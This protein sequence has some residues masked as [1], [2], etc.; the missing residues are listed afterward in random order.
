M[1]ARQL[2]AGRSRAVSGGQ[3]R[4]RTTPAVAAALVASVVALSAAAPAAADTQGPIDFE[5]YS[6]GSVDGQD[7]WAKTGPFDVAIADNSTFPDAPASFGDQSLRMSD[8]VTSGSFGNQ[9]FSKPT[10][11]AAG[12]PTADTGGFPTGTLRSRFSTS[13]DFA[14]VTPDAEQPG[15]HTSISPDRGDGAR[16]SYV[17]IEDSPTGWNLFFVDYEDVAPLGSDGDLDDGCG[18]GDSFS[19]TEIASDLS[20]TPHNLEIVM[21]LVN[22]P[23]NDI[24]QVFLDGELVHEGT[25]WEDY[26]RFCSE[27]G[28]GEGGPRADQS[29][30]VRN[31]LFR[32]AGT[33]HP[34]NAGAGFLIDGFLVS[35][36]DPSL[37]LTSIC[38]YSGGP[39]DGQHL[40]RVTSTYL[41]DTDYT[42][43][44]P[45]NAAGVARVATTGKTWFLGVQDTTKIT[46]TTNSGTQTVTKAANG[47]VCSPLSATITTPP[48]GASYSKDQI[49]AADFA[50]GGNELVSCVGTVADGASIDTASVGQESFEVTATSWDGSTATATSEYTVYPPPTGNGCNNTT[51]ILGA[52]IGWYPANPSGM[53][54]LKVA[55]T[56]NNQPGTSQVVPSLTVHDHNR[57][58][59]HNGAAS[60]AT[61]VQLSTASN[62]IAG[63]PVSPATLNR[64]VTG[65]GIAPRTF[66]T[67]LT[68]GGLLTLNRPTTGA[69]PAGSSLK[70]E[71]GSARSVTDA[72]GGA[73]TEL[74]SATA[75]FTGADVGLSVSGTGIP[76]DTTIQSISSSTQ[77]VL[78]TPISLAGPTVT[79]GE[80]M[81]TSTTRQITGASITSAVRITSVATGFAPTDRGLRVTGTC[82][83]GAAPDYTVPAAVYILTNGPS[84]ADTT[85][86]L[87]AGQ[88]E[89]NLTIGEAS[90]TAPLNGEVVA[91][92]GIQVDLNPASV[93][94][95]GACSEQ[96]P[97]G[98][99]IPAKWYNPGSFTGAG[100]T[101]AQP[102][103]TKAIGQLYFDT[104]TAKY[105]AFVVERKAL[106]ADDPI[107]VV[108]YDIVFPY[109]PLSLAMC[110]G[111]ATGPGLGTSLTVMAAT[112]SQAAL[113]LGTGRPGTA[114]VRSTLPSAT[115]GYTSTAYVRSD[116]PGVTF[117]PASAFLRLCVYPDGKP[118][119]VDFY[120]GNG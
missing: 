91:Q 62:G 46:Y 21:E 86:G 44:S 28:G 67:S 5:S 34:A 76:E 7:G 35:T 105:S 68:A 88:T 33:A 111:T 30:I 73:P 82:L 3:W 29:R 106:T 65:P 53:S 77:V 64:V 79:I 16:M 24:V 100:L 51:G 115:G 26:Y 4:R 103:D 75:N 95:F 59:Y 81:L 66:A 1:H 52:T 12:E 40:W 60:G 70:I 63:L 108:H 19:E 2:S 55:C 49:V 45:F 114:Q 14:S 119:A 118:N 85:G 69:V 27:S 92:Q 110:P 48:D 90:A 43:F 54:G 84:N 42:S 17:R 9:A 18:A 72:T 41:A 113:P 78:D 13:F 120:C 80:T 50:C 39:Y 96:Q 89:C 98:F 32:Q 101:N 61:T 94:G 10:V 22:G 15:L 97:E 37:N 87:A 31:V 6:I 11:D 93:P 109:A 71:N 36:V 25:S 74:S 99:V 56:F 20:R 116:T 47:S 83:N 8:A 58:Q 57:A 102:A 107:G 104:S 112:A 23:L 38:T 117:T